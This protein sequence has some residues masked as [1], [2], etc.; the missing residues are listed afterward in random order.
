MYKNWLNF[1]T[2]SFNFSM[3]LWLVV[4]NF[5]NSS[6]WRRYKWNWHPS[7]KG[8]K[9][10]CIWISV[11]ITLCRGKKCMFYRDKELIGCLRQNV[12]AGR[13]FNLAH[14]LK[15][16]QTAK[17]QTR[18]PESLYLT[19][20]W[21]SEENQASTNFT[22]INLN[23]DLVCLKLRFCQSPTCHKIYFYNSSKDK[24][25]TAYKYII[26]SNRKYGSTT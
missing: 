10:R 8:K 14:F 1:Y 25:F 23:V 3:L 24:T 18:F 15:S 6:E 12:E 11:G 13:D 4:S 9:R 21:D 2:N 26:A 19:R 22:E 16:H 20:S 7:W 17:V 5:W